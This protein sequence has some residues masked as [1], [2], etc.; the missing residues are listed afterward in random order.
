MLTTW[1]GSV[2]MATDL[3]PRSVGIATEGADP[4]INTLDI[5]GRA[6]VGLAPK[7]AR[8][9]R[10]GL[11]V[12]IPVEDVVV[13][14]LV[15]VRPGDTHGRPEFALPGREFGPELDAHFH[16]QSAGVCRLWA[17]FRL[18]DGHVITVPFTVETS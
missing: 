2:E 15:R 9:V 7:T 5:G 1:A 17:Q 4:V 18:G 10:E 16:F 11:E 13:G 8:V 14:D 6:L 3:A 12:D